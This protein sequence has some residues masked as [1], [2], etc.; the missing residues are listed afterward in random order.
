MKAKTTF[1]LVAIG[2]SVQASPQFNNQAAAQEREELHGQQEQQSKSDEPSTKDSDGTSKETEVRTSSKIF[3]DLIR[4]EKEMGKAKTDEA[5]AKN[6]GE[7][8]ALFIEVAEHPHIGKNGSL[9]NMNVRLQTRLKGLETRT[10]KELKRR[11][12]PEPP[13]MVEER[14]RENQKRA[15]AGG[16]SQRNQ[17]GQSRLGGQSGFGSQADSGTN[18]RGE[19]GG[20]EG[21]QA[22][23]GGGNAGPGPDYGWQLV[24]LI[25][26]TIRPEYWSVAGG[27]G[28]AIYFGNKRA[29]VIHG[30]WRVQEDVADLLTALRGG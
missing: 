13:E 18:S 14:R 20:A 4:L 15:A 21:G 12:I 24:N 27:P 25:R 19:Q 3:Q 23:I 16:A 9:Q 17:S 7:L 29:L 2:L 28:K 22:G 1:L 26:N 8:C 30:S 6:I 5:K 10:V 11:K